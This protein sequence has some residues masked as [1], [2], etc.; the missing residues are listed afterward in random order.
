MAKDVVDAATADLPGQVPASV[1]AQLSLL[2]ADGLPAVRASAR[3]LA[4]DYGVPAAVATHLIAR[5]G[6]LAIEVLDLI[7]ADRALGQPLLDGFGYLR[8]EVAYAVSH[9]GAL[10]VEDVL[11]RRVRLLIES[12]DGG[13][14][15]APEVVAIMAALLGWNRRRR[16]AELRRYLDFAAASAA[17]LSETASVAEAVTEALIPA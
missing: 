13:T 17:A 10:H 5:Y 7:G 14:S 16:A 15:A 8:A 4:G 3:R 9:E 11:A 6:S 1:T 2:G 12:P